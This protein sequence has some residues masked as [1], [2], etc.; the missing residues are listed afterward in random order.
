MERVPNKISKLF[1]EK[2]NEKILSGPRACHTTLLLLHLICK[3][4]YLS[5]YPTSLTP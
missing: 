1:N 3:A 2:R 4:C 5:F